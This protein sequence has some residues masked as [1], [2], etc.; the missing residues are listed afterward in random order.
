MKNAHIARRVF[1]IALLGTVTI[2]GM[3][4]PASAQEQPPPAATRSLQDLIGRVD[5]GVTLSVID[6]A[7]NEITGNLATI[8]ASSL[9]L[10]IEGNHRELAERDVLRVTRPPYGMSRLKGGLIG[11]GVGGCQSCSS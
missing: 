11:A 1:V 3:A 8:S 5:S 10:L 6:T 4:V 7:G 2:I 9:T